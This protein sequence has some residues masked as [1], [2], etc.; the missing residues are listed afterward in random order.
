MNEHVGNDAALY[1]LGLLDHDDRAAIDTH[2]EHCAACSLVLAEAFDDVAAAVAAGSQQSAPAELQSRLESS[3]A[4]ARM[5][6]VWYAAVAAVIVL[7]ILPSAYLL[8]ENHSMQRTMIAE[9]KAMD[10]IAAAPHRTVAFSGT[11]ARV[12]YGPDGSWYCV[13]V[14]G[15]HQAIDVVWMHDGGKTLLG[16]AVPHG[17]V[18]ILYL[19][20][21]HRMHR[22]ALVSGDRTVAQARLVF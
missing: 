14:R 8:R 4:P 11:D 19:P 21:S 5:R 15:V 12:M 1:A 13:V 7:A 9:S 18:A 2:V 10:R 22:L 20:K 3:L 6:P 16:T 17:D